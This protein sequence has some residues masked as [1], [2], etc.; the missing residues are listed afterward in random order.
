MS[1]PGRYDPRASRQD[2]GHRGNGSTWRPLLWVS[3]RPGTTVHV[4]HHF[5][6]AT[7]LRKILLICFCQFHQRWNK[8]GTPR[9]SN[10]YVFSY[11]APSSTDQRNTTSWITTATISVTRLRSSSRVTL[12]R[13]TSQISQQKYLQRNQLRPKSSHDWLYTG[14][15]IF[16]CA[17]KKIAGWVTKTTISWVLVSGS[18][19]IDA[20]SWPI[21]N[22]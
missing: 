3:G 1:H 2:R 6:K 10:C 19:H 11:T 8:L 18:I 5:I 13:P 20:T 9:K 4:G 16:G 14:V 22:S 12:F 7:D 21:N 17:S 15:N